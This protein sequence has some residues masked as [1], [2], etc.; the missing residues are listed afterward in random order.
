MRALFLKAMVAASLGLSAAAQ[1]AAAES[2]HCVNRKNK[3][4]KGAST[5]EECKR[6]YRWVKASGP[7]PPQKAQLAK[8][9]RKRHR[10][11]H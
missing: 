4:V 2:F 8:V 10:Y 11:H 7:K 1:P 5:A 9:H 6:P 3:E